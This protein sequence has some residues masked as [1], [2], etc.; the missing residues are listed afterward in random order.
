MRADPVN[1][2]RSTRASSASGMPA[3]GPRPW[4]TFSTPGGSPASRHSRPSQSADSG[5]CS[6]GFRMDPLPQKI[7]GNAFHATFGNGVLNEIRSAATP[8]GRRRVSTV[9]FGIEAVVVRPYERRPSP[10]TK[11]PISTAASVSPRASASGL[12]VSAATSSLA[13]SRRSRSSSAI[14]RTTFPRSTGVRAAHPGCASRAASTAAAAS[15]APERAT[16]QSSVP[17]AGRLLSSH[18]PVAGGRSSPATRFGASAL[19]RPTSL[20]RRRGS[21][22]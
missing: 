12:P 14:A 8:T 1:E 18:V 6:D 10:A 15:S 3:S 11:R 2:T 19:T 22:P 16:R 13:S 20:R 4:S 7:D 5:V 21:R 17:S 9:R